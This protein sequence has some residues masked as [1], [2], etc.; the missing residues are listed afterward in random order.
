M[1][2]KYSG[3]LTEMKSTNE[4]QLKCHI[5]LPVART[6]IYIYILSLVECK[7]NNHLPLIAHCYLCIFVCVCMSIGRLMQFTIYAGQHL[8]SKCNLPKFMIDNDARLCVKI[9]QTIQLS[10]ILALS[11]PSIYFG[12]LGICGRQKKRYFDI[13]KCIKYTKFPHSIGFELKLFLV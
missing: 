7:F 13:T 8:Q 11:L 2:A 12:N 10:I 6:N 5:S 9:A 1:K 4:S 3:E